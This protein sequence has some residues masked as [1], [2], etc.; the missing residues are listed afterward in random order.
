MGAGPGS[1]SAVR[2]GGS[3]LLKQRYQYSEK[4]RAGFVELRPGCEMT[5]N[6]LFDALGNVPGVQRVE[7]QKRK[8]AQGNA[9]RNHDMQQN[10]IVFSKIRGSET[11]PRHMEF[12]VARHQHTQA[13]DVPYTTTVMFK[14]PPQYLHAEAW[15]ILREVTKGKELLPDDVQ[16]YME[17][18][19]ERHRE[20]EVRGRPSAS[21]AEG[22]LAVACPPVPGITTAPISPPPGLSQVD[23]MADG[24]TS[25]TSPSAATPSLKNE[26]GELAAEAAQGLSLPLEWAA[27]K[28]AITS[29][30]I[31]E[32]M[33]SHALYVDMFSAADEGS[34]NGV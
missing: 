23:H 10:V 6:Q 24:A 25:S 13:K 4:S 12:E 5:G 16:K 20:S 8:Q 29:G 19:I 21:A 26:P 11:M 34:Q 30:S 3:R 15:R 32:P 28:I 17:Q 31:S 1:G 18:S 33:A 9:S 2:Y 14:D 7:W 22:S 27:D